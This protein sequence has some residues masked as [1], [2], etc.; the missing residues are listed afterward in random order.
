MCALYPGMLCHVFW[1]QVEYKIICFTFITE[2]YVP[3]AEKAGN[4]SKSILGLLQ[5]VGQC[6]M[7]QTI[8]KL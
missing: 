8:S 3:S 1:S 4:V 2:M 6:S 7:S 5:F